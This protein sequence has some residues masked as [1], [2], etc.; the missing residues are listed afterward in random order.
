MS[1]EIG[2]RR[3]QPVGMDF[4][5]RTFAAAMLDGDAMALRRV[6]AVEE[7]PG[8]TVLRS[9]GRADHAEAVASIFT[10]GDGNLATRGALEEAV[11]AGSV[12]ASGVYAGV[13]ASQHLRPG[14]QWTGLELTDL[15]RPERRLL[16]LRT[17]VLLREELT[18]DAPLRTL[19]FVSVAR[20]GLH[21]LRAQA[22]SERI[23]PGAA[24]QAPADGAVLTG[25]RDG[26]DWARTPGDA[27]GIAAVAVQR[28]SEGDGIRTVERL[29][30][31]RADPHQP[32][33]LDEA[34]ETL[35]EAADVGF[36]V[37]L[38]EHCRVWAQRWAEVD[39]QIP[40]DPAAQLAL[41]FA[42]FQ[43]WTNAGVSGDWDGGDWGGGE[44]AVG[45]RGLSG[46]AYAG[47]VFWD[48]DAF[49]LPA[50][51]SV[52][53]AA[54]RAMLEYRIRRLPA[55]RA[56]AAVQGGAGARFPWESADDGD[57]VTPDAAMI[58]TELVTITTGQLEEHITADVAW[59]ADDY[60]SWTD[61]RD[62][63]TGPGRPLIVET[64]RY[65]ASRARRSPDGRAHLD[66]VIGPDE[67]H[68]AVD[69][70]AFTNV[71]ARWNLRRGADLVPGSAEAQEWRALAD[72]LVDG[73]QPGTGR[74]EQFAGYDQLESLLAADVAPLPFAADLLLGQART[75][76]SQLIKQPDLLMA[77]LLLP[78]ELPPDSFVPEL[79]FYGPRTSHGSSLSP[80]AMASLLARAG[81]GD[82]ALDLLRLALDLD[83]ADLTGTTA[84]GLHLATIAGTW[85][86][87][88]H[89]IVGLSVHDGVLLLD[90]RLPSSWGSVRLRLCCLG[91]HLVLAISPDRLTVGADRP[92]WVRPQGS[93][94]VS[95]AA[96]T[97]FR[98]DGRGWAVEAAG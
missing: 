86:A 23:R 71:M 85:Q 29:A 95:V 91:R 54:A 82:E 70:N 39:V 76:G 34:A 80:A 67:Y 97:V 49:V 10:I 52:C 96:P 13:G 63:L 75:S 92:V 15:G 84:A 48:A 11:G 62:F 6:P 89:G 42:L 14:P 21:V 16:N 20:P 3:M 37:L 73:Y 38:A 44:L 93:G 79:D 7:D 90:P 51:A 35:R 1:R 9:S 88:V 66:G 43:L 98:R 4:V 94:R 68:E 56:A 12:L 59:A 69:D 24:L 28:I 40:D 78:Q 41:R 61:D 58:G 45:A 65:W 5:D 47:H 31:Y 46:T 74:H 26:L 33:A 27:G 81:R 64:A 60:A 83:L 36:D 32:P 8:W 72:A 87:L 17:G 53:P 30:I 77:R 19:R 25:R 57:D 55:A 2:S 18:G 22:A 50:M